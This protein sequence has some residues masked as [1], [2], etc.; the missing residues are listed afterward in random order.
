MEGASD[1]SAPG[2]NRVAESWRFGVTCP[3]ERGSL[4]ED[5]RLI[6]RS[7]PGRS[8]SISLDEPARLVCRFC[9][10]RYSAVRPILDDA[11]GDTARSKLYDDRGASSFH[12]LRSS[13]RRCCNSDAHVCFSRSNEL[14]AFWRAA[15]AS[16]T[17]CCS[18][19]SFVFCDVTVCCKSLICV[20]KLSAS[21]SL[22]FALSV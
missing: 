18:C 17:F 1:A 2:L 14:L 9:R 6:R 7:G 20:C 21:S 5:G 10:P 13:S 11:T 4:D 3:D 19:T 12:L 15:S 16:S 8:S 22:D